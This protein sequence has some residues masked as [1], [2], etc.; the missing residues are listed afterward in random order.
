MSVSGS[1]S[2][3]AL[4]LLGVVGVV[5]LYFGL[6]GTIMS[7]SFAVAGPAASEAERLAYWRPIQNWYGGVVLASFVLLVG[8]GVGVVRRVMRTMRRRRNR[9]GQQAVQS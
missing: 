3:A 1:K 5:G 7:G 8:V 6:M 9:S 2:T 4:W